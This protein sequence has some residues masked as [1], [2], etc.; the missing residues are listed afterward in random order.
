MSGRPT[1]KNTSQKTDLYSGEF[2]YT[3]SQ[4]SVTQRN[5]LNVIA[6]DKLDRQS[7]T[8]GV[9]LV[10][11]VQAE[12]FR[13][14]RNGRKKASGR[15]TD[16]HAV[17]QMPL[18]HCV[19]PQ[20][21]SQQVCRRYSTFC[22]FLISCHPRPPMYPNWTLLTVRVHCPHSLAEGHIHPPPPTPS[23]QQGNCFLFRVVT[24]NKQNN[25]QTNE[26]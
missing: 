26:E 5:L 20:N 12:H 24:L 2:F 21:Q 18:T 4:R 3:Y 11:L 22:S 25:T 14:Q 7:F 8:E 1:N 16:R 19:F 6:H 13:V 23:K 15:H 17:S 10:G 9:I